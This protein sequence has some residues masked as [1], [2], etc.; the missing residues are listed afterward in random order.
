MILSKN[1]GT[2]LPFISNKLVSFAS[3]YLMYA[4]FCHLQPLNDPLLQNK[5]YTYQ[6]IRAIRVMVI[7]GQNWAVLTIVIL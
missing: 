2:F 6:S 1:S 4:D 5:L 7:F 3:N